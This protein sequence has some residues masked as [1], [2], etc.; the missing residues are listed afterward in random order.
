MFGSV[1]RFRHFVGAFVLNVRGLIGIYVYV[2]TWCTDNLNILRLGS[3][4]IPKREVFA[5]GSSVPSM[6]GHVSEY[7][8]Q[9]QKNIAENKK[10]LAGLGLD[11]FK[12]SVSA[13]TRSE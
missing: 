3:R 8:L 13:V 7:E 5:S 4:C 11:K 10:I 9:R 1:Y 6:N 2:Y 12:V